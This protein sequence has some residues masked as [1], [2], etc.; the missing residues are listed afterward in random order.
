[1]GSLER[2]ITPRPAQA[3][4]EVNAN[5]L[6]EPKVN[7]ANQDDSPLPRDDIDNRTVTDSATPASP[8]PVTCDEA[9][10]P[11]TVLASY[12]H[13]DDEYNRRV[14]DVVQRL[15]DDEGI[16]AWSDHFVDFPKSGWPAW[17]REQLRDRQ[18]VLVFASEPY[19][20]RAEGREQAGRGLG[21][22][23]EHGYIRSAS[24]QNQRINERFIPVG[25]GPD[26]RLFV[27]PDLRDYTYFNLDSPDDFAKLLA[28]LRRTPLIT[29]RTLGRR[30]ATV[31]ES[32]A[33]PTETISNTTEP[34]NRSVGGGAA[35]VEQ[36]R[37]LPRAS[38]VFFNRRFIQAFPGSKRD[39]PFFA[40]GGE[41]ASCETARAAIECSAKER[42][43]QPY[44]VLGA[45]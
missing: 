45:G 23:W 31:D 2:P 22:I 7:M 8:D 25:F 24:Y 43:D 38:T 12:A 42:L 5:R 13:I 40:A 44:L 41:R 18:W 39:V 36:A 37:Q 11:I 26:E 27:P 14:L 32:P 9:E 21:V 34:A 20:R 6:K 15:R 16:D 30:S 1:M 29:P 4:C 19:L 3:L 28:V 33:S 10:A 35:I 17:M